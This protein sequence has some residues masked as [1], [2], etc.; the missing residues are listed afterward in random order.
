MAFWEAHDGVCRLLDDSFKSESHG[1]RTSMFLF[2]DRLGYPWE[3]RAFGRMNV[4]LR[5]RFFS[6][7]PGNER[8]R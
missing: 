3:N 2:I 6:K 5:G 8:G 4:A 1:E 7:L